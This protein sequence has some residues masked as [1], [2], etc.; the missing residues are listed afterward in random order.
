MDKAFIESQQGKLE[1]S[2]KDILHQLEQFA[3]KDEDPNAPKGDW[4]T[5]YPTRPEDPTLEDQADDFQE[6]DN[7][8][9][10]EH[11]LE[12]KLKDVN[13][14]LEK[15]KEGKYGVCEKCG[16]EIEKM[17]LEAMPEARTC[18]ACNK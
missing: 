5:K 15:I 13:D 9:S 4:E 10:V 18:M 11:S 7:M 6:Y 16:K 3:K 1:T 17:R 12:L 8:L 2:K 14:A